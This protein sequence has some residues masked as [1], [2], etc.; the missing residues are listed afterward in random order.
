MRLTGNETEDQ[1]EIGAARYGLARKATFG[2]RRQ[3][4]CTAIWKRM[5]AL[6]VL[7]E[8]SDQDE[9]EYRSLARELAGYALPTAPAEVLDALGDEELGDLAVLFFA[10][11]AVRSRRLAVVRTLTSAMSSPVSNSFTAE[12]PSGG[13]T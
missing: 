3:A 10:Q 9:R 1:V 2:L 4:R 8:P 7:E 5:G 6:E 11:G 13:S 12:I